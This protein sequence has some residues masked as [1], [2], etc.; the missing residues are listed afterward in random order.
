M[1][2]AYS[3]AR[4]VVTTAEEAQMGDR[5]AEPVTSVQTIDQVYP[6]EYSNYFWEPTEIDLDGGL[7]MNVVD[8]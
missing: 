2:A 4:A 3:A 5:P 7:D 6:P 8:N 1:P